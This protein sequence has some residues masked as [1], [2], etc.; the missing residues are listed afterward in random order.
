MTRRFLLTEGIFVPHPFPDV[1]K[2]VFFK[3]FIS[4]SVIDD[5]ILPSVANTLSQNPRRTV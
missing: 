3:A 2:G 4:W 5:T 1:G